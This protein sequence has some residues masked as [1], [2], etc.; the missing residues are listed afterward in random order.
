MRFRL[1]DSSC[2]NDESNCRVLLDWFFFCSLVDAKFEI[3][4]RGL[5]AGRSGERKGVWTGSH[6]FLETREKL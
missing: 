1:I 5:S 3:R 6:L 4:T 2:S